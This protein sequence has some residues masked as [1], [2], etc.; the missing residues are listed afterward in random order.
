LKSKI[1]KL[2]CVAALGIPAILLLSFIMKPLR[3]PTRQPVLADG[4]I[5]IVIQSS[6]KDKSTEIVLDRSFLGL[7]ERLYQIGLKAKSRNESLIFPRAGTKSIAGIA[8]LGP[9]IAAVMIAAYLP[10]ARR[11]LGEKFDALQPFRAL[12]EIQMRHHQPHRA[13]VLQ[14]QRRA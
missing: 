9:R 8:L 5:T 2:V 3:G 10:I 1:L 7:N 14:F 4:D 11:I 6:R 12:P 13:A